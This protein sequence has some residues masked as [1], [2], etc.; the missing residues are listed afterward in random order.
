MSQIFVNTDNTNLKDKLYTAQMAGENAK[1]AEDA[2][3]KIVTRVIGKNPGFTTAKIANPKGYSIRLK[4]SKLQQTPAETKC[5][6]S[7]EIV[8]YP[9]TFSSSQKGGGEAMV[10]TGMSGSATAT[11]RGKFAVIDC[12]EAISESLVAKTIPLMRQDMTKR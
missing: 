5:T 12:V 2:M 10:T 8:R 7:G 9:N 3:Q 6:V 4:I 1:A 11:G